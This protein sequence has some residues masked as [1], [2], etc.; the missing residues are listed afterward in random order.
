MFCF[1]CGNRLSD[2]SI[3]C[4]RCGV[5][6]R[7]TT[8]RV[9]N[10]KPFAGQSSTR[11][12]AGGSNVVPNRRDNDGEIEDNYL[13]HDRLQLQESLEPEEWTD[14]EEWLNDESM[15]DA[16][17]WGEEEPITDDSEEGG[18]IR[19]YRGPRERVIFSINPAFYPVTTAYL[20]AGFASILMAAISSF[21]NLGFMI[22]IGAVIV[23][24]VPAIIRH[25]K[26]IHTIFT[27]TSVKIEISEG[28]FSKTTRNIPLRHIQDVS[29]R[30]NFKERILGIGDIILDTPSMETGLIMKNVNNPRYYADLIIEQ[31]EKW[32]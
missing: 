12:T 32:I 9:R 5:R 23:S 11:F 1:R 25:I 20:L 10:S 24:F 7:T 30:E 17:Q 15:G 19:P 22:A 29:V 26:H 16:E 2:E 18:E 8:E 14:Q 21:L 13:G 4:N 31:L 6:L 27:L 3:Y 28:L